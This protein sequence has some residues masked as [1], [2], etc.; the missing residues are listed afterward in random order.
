MRKAVGIPLSGD[1]EQAEAARQ[2]HGRGAHHEWLGLVRRSASLAERLLDEPPR[3]NGEREAG[4][5][6]QDHLAALRRP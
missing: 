3:Q 5:N 6:H 1:A 4:A 2:H